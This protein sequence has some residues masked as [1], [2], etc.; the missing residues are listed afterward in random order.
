MDCQDFL[1]RFSDYID[2]RAEEDVACEIETHRESCR[3]C[4]HYADTLEAGRGLL[5]R[6][7]DLDVPS[8]F[9]PRL[10]HRILHLEDGAALARSSLSS[11]ATVASVLAVAALLAS[12]AWAPALTG[13]EPNVDLPPV[14][15]AEPASPTF[16]PEPSKPT[17][18]RNLSLFP[19]TEF[20]DGIWGNPHDLLR[21]YSPTL[22]RRRD[23]IFLRVGI[24]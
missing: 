5:E 21:E 17:F 15:A 1:T 24:E 2:G 16:T 13:P 9:R 18:T 12:A 10:Q 4:R 6:L 3:L 14:N 8:D 22:D 11:G 23:Q 7:P 20:Q 19:T